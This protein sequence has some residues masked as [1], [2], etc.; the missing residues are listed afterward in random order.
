MSLPIAFLAEVRDDVDEAYQYYECHK[1][2]LGDN[3][4][5]AASTEVLV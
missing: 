3:F 1:P 5:A 4:L 2:G